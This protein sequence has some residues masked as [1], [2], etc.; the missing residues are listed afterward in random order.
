MW[1]VL[2]QETNSQTFIT[3]LKVK[4]PIDP[5]IFFKHVIVGDA[6]IRPYSL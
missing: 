1:N 6:F 2:A 3:Q 5:F 4:D